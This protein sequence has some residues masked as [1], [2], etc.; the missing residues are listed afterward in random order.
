MYHFARL[1]TLLYADD[2][3]V[4]AESIAELQKALNAVYEYCNSFKLTANTT[5]TKGMVFSNGKIRILP[6]LFFGNGKLEF[7]FEYQYL[8]ILFNYNVV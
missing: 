1:Y 2:T 4:L 6:D 8:G 7:V 3:I 5:K